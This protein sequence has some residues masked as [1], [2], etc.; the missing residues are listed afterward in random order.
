MEEQFFEDLKKFI[1]DNSKLHELHIYKTMVENKGITYQLDCYKHSLNSNYYIDVVRINHDYSVN[2][3]MYTRDLDKLPNF[4]TL[5]QVF[6]YERELY[7]AKE[8]EELERSKRIDNMLK[9]VTIVE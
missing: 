9:N 8:K 5:E 4:E 1:I 7:D 6:D 2:I 3:S